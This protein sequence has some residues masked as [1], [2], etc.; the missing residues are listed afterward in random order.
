[1][2][3][4]GVLAFFTNIFHFRGTVLPAILPQIL[5]ATAVAAGVYVGWRF[6]LFKGFSSVGHSAL[7]GLVRW[8][9]ARCCAHR[10]GAVGGCSGLCVGC[11][12]ESSVRLYAWWV[13]VWVWV[14]V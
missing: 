8:A 7:G 11:R 13:W 2:N 9:S 6:Q 4:E 5:M 10:A 14:C 1:M 3:E 12:C